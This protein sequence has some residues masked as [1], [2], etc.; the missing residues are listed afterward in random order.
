MNRFNQEGLIVLL[1]AVCL[2]LTCAAFVYWYWFMLPDDPRNIFSPT[3][4]DVGAL[5][6]FPVGYLVGLFEILTGRS[7]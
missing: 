6:V 7:Y 3:L 4:S 5:M 2:T 1:S